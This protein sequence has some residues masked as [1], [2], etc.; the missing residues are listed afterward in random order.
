MRRVHFYGNEYGYTGDDWVNEDSFH[1]VSRV[2]AWPVKAG[3]RRLYFA[4][5]A[6][7]REYL[8]AHPDARP[9]LPRLGFS[10]AVYTAPPSD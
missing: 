4:S 6:L 9:L 7:R 10:D 8:A 2:I 1:T 5:R 3:H